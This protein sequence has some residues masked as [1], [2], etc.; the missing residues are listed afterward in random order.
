[1]NL[2]KN[3]LVFVAYLKSGDLK[4]RTI[5]YGRR[6]RKTWRTT[7]LALPKN[8]LHF[9]RFVSSISKK[10]CVTWITDFSWLHPSHDLIWLRLA[11]L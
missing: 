6:D 4:K 5:T 10:V 9:T 1:M 11:A 3:S 2:P 7:G 8:L